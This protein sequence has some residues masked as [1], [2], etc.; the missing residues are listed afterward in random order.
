MSRMKR[1]VVYAA[2]LAVGWGYVVTD[3]ATVLAKAATEAAAPVQGCVPHVIGV[4]CTNDGACSNI[5][6]E[7]CNDICVANGFGGGLHA[8]SLCV[9]GPDGS[10]ECPCYAGND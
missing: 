6:D 4:S 5:T 7:V 2:F 1:L 10:F 9:D 8:S 3:G